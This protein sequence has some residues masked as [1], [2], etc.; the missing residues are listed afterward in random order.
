MTNEVWKE[1]SDL[2]DILNDIRKDEA[3]LKM[4]VGTFDDRV[5]A[6]VK[7]NGLNMEADF[8]IIDLLH[9]VLEKQ[10]GQLQ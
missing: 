3:S 5:K 7:S 6:F 4:K 2:H 8:N 1:I 9:T 10:S